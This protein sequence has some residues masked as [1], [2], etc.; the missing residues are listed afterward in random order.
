MREAP[1][2]EIQQ[3]VGL[4]SFYQDCDNPAIKQEI[5]ANSIAVLRNITGLEYHCGATTL[6][7]RRKRSTAKTITLKFKVVAKGDKDKLSTDPATELARIKKELRDVVIPRFKASL[8]NRK[9]WDNLNKFAGSFSSIREIGNSAETC[10][11]PGFV[12]SAMTNSLK[13]NC[14]KL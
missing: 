9:N 6:V 4:L 5:S 11:Q 10:G 13:E 7:N 12:K 8:T 1:N 3:V 2:A 14:G